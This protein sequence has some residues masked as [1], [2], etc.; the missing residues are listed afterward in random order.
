MLNPI[1]RSSKCFSVQRAAIADSPKVGNGN[2]VVPVIHG[3]YPGAG[4][5]LS[6]GKWRRQ[7]SSEVDEN[8]EEKRQHCEEMG[9][10]T[11]RKERRDAFPAELSKDFKKKKMIGSMQMRMIE[12]RWKWRKALGVVN[13]WKW[14]RIRTQKNLVKNQNIL[15]FLFIR[16]FFLS[17]C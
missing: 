14:Q 9:K 16:F 6:N 13:Q 2:L 3:D 12:G 11:S 8:E 5:E 15:K 17:F 4:S 10:K 7:K 1:N